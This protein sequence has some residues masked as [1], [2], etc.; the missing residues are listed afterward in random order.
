MLTLLTVYFTIQIFKSSVT[1]KYYYGVQ[2]YCCIYDT[3]CYDKF[4]NLPILFSKGRFIFRGHAYALIAVIHYAALTRHDKW[5]LKCAES[6]SH[7]LS[8]T[9]SPFIKLQFGK[10]REWMC[11]YLRGGGVSW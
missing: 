4:H 8:Y 11:V 10:Y 7:V 3:C 5:P 9:H 6:R 1:Y 2:F